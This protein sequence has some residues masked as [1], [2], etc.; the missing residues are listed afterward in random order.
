MYCLRANRNYACS[1]YL[2]TTLKQACQTDALII[3]H[4]VGPCWIQ[5][6][7]LVR[8]QEVDKAVNQLPVPSLQ[9]TF[10]QTLQGEWMSFV[11]VVS[12]RLGEFGMQT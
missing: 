6:Q 10:G 7:R 9:L 1:N 12:L 3:Y 2:L 4:L 5:L 11:L 8:K